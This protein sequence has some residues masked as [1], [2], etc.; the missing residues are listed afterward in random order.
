MHKVH[1]RGRQRFNDPIQKPYVE[2]IFTKQIR[3]IQKTTLNNPRGAALM[4]LRFWAWWTVVVFMVKE[5]FGGLQDVDVA[6]VR[7]IALK[8]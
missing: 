4:V 8:C 3:N 7:R 2:T 6:L 5:D 1:A